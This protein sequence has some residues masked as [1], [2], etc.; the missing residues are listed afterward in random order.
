MPK[1]YFDE[2]VAEGYDSSSEDAFEPP[3]VDSVVNFLADLAGDGGAS[4]G[5]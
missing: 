3:F 5:G 1:D 4:E 2:Q